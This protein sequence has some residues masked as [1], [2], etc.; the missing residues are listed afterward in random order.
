[1]NCLQDAEAFHL[2]LLESADEPVWSVDLHFRLLV[3]NG[4]FSRMLQQVS[5]LAAAPGAKPEEYLSAGL[6]TCWRARYERALRDGPY[7]LDSKDPGGGNFEFQFDPIVQA[8]VIAGVSV[9]GR[10]RPVET[11]RD[12]DEVYRAVVESAPVGII[13]VVPAGTVLA[14]NPAAARTLGYDS[15][16]ELIASVTSTAR[17]LWES[18]EDRVRVNRLLEQANVDAGVVCRWKCKDGTPI[19]VAI[20]SRRVAGDGGR[21]R[22][23]ETFFRDISSIIASR[24]RM[25]ENQQVMSLAQVSAH[26]GVF[27]WNLQTAT[28]YWS[29]ELIEL[30]GEDPAKIIPSM[31]AWMNTIHSE[32]RERVLQELMHQVT[33]PEV[34]VRIEYRLL[35]GLRWLAMISAVRCDPEG[36]PLR[37]VG[38]ALDITEQ[39]RMEEASRLD[40]EILGNIAAGMLLVRVCDGTIVHAN[41]YALNM[42]GYSRDE[43]TGQHIAML[44]APGERSPLEVAEETVRHLRLCGTWSGEVL[45][46]RKD[47]STFWCDAVVT[48]FQHESYGPVWI[49]VQRDITARREAGAEKERMEEQLRQTQKMESVGQIAGGVAHEFN[50][51]LGVI[52]GYAEL[53]AGSIHLP[54]RLWSYADSIRRAGESASSLTRQLL[55][56]SRKQEIQPRRLDANAL[57]QDFEKLARQLVNEN[58]AFVL[59][60]ESEFGSIH[61]DPEQLLQ[62]LMS[63]TI[64]A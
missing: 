15:P 46:I 2:A 32:D 42:F 38:V 16:G 49:S 64:N 37:I 13:Q 21:T 36:K 34:S 11:V 10:S 39:R 9:A 30:H 3:F 52:N 17:Q 47:R 24:E 33:G 57:I 12:S 25:L 31:D 6:A 5:G 56:F 51:L 60:L 63:L 28:G 59:D 54:E 45:K 18:P 23:Y 48:S 50:N 7:Q 55:A 26:F 29:P 43:L 44:N 27:T 61:A 8:G 4:G 14:A 19:W 22:Y 53:L 62:V 40:S 41:E 35:D 1:M 58:M 20:N